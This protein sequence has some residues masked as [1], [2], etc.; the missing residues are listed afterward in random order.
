LSWRL[1]QF[2]GADTYGALQTVW[3]EAAKFKA[4]AAVLSASSPPLIG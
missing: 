2:A 4:S 1:L 3:G